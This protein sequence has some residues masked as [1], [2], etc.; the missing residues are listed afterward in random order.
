VILLYLSSQILGQNFFSG[1]L[2]PP[3]MRDEGLGTHLDFFRKESSGKNRI[4]QKT[5]LIGGFFGLKF[6][7]SGHW[8][9]NPVHRTPSPA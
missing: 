7:Q 2:R 5:R 9:L 4:N 8:E 1:A 6:P 3:T